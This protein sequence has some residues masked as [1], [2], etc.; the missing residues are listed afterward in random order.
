M[1]DDNV[2]KIIEVAG[3]SAESLEDAMQGAVSKASRSLQHLRW[4]EVQDIRGH[5]EN[6]RIAHF[7]VVMKIGFT[8][9]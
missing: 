4:F 2:Y 7:Q 3:S 1:T 5:L 9:D 6:G 8:L